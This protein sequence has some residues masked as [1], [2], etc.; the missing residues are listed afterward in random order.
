MLAMKQTATFIEIVDTLPRH[1]ALMR[2]NLRKEDAD[3]ILR[4]GI[5][6]EKCLSLVELLPIATIIL[7]NNSVPLKTIFSRS[8]SWKFFKI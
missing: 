2:D 7:S 8:W 3:E 5:S 6:I 1:T 4:L